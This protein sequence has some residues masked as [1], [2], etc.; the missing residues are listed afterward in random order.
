MATLSLCWLRASRSH[1]ARARFALRT[2][3]IFQKKSVSQSTRNAL[4]REKSQKKF[5]TP[6][7]PLRALR[8]AK[9]TK[10]FEKKISVSQ[11]TQNALKRIDMQKRFL[12]L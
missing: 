1:L 10:I 4:N 11:S 5:F 9:F 7:D 2:H 8:S 12:P 6:F 3:K